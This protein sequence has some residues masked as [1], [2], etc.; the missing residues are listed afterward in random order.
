M[1]GVRAALLFAAVA[2]AL[3]LLWLRLLVG[4]LTP[5]LVVLAL[6]PSVLILVGVSLGGRGRR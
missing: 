4:S 5:E 3:C 1:M 2:F 6:A